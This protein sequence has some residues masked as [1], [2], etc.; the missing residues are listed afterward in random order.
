MES[1]M[2]GRGMSPSNL[3][4]CRYEVDIIFSEG[5]GGENTADYQRTKREAFAVA[6]NWAQD[7]CVKYAEVFDLMAHKGKQNCWRVFPSGMIQNITGK[8]EGK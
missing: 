7:K 8:G 4:Y 5:G 6:K 3:V 1:D 2:I